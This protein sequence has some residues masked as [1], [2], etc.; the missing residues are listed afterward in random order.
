MN[1]GI[2]I[3]W[4]S[5]LIWLTSFCALADPQLSASASLTPTNATAGDTVA[6]QFT[7]T[8]V[9]TPGGSDLTN[10]HLDVACPMAQINGVNQYLPLISV[11][12]PGGSVSYLFAEGEISGVK[13]DYPM[14]SQGANRTFSASFQIPAGLVNGSVF[15][16]S[17]TLTWAQSPG[18]LTLASN[19]RLTAAPLLQATLLPTP[20]YASPGGRITYRAECANQGSGIARKAWMVVPLPPGTHLLHAVADGQ[21]PA[22][23][24]STTPYTPAQASSDN[25]VRANFTPGIVDAAGTPL[26][27]SDDFWLFPQSTKTLALF[28]DDPNL[29]L[30][31]TGGS[32]EFIWQIVDDGSP[33]GAVIEQP[34]AIFSDEWSLTYATPHQTTIRQLPADLRLIKVGDSMRLN[35]VGDAETT[36]QVQRSSQLTSWSDLGS[37]TQTNPGYFQFE[38]SNPFPDRGFYRLSAPAP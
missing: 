27:P 17:A 6:F 2:S 3:I 26:D 19:C 23:W 38:D 7:V 8:N 28:L 31:P 5:V 29:N 33:V 22:L 1:R 34:L 21:S 36:Y 10:S 20:P 9:N 14:L 12:A 25:F 11:M 15:Q 13:V 18:T 32:Q 35:F 16:V 37:A 30:L 4:C 24:Y